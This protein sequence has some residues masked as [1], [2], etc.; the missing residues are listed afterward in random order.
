MDV[1]HFGETC[2]SVSEAV[3]CKVVS[4]CVLCLNI[5]SSQSS[6]DRHI[7]CLIQRRTVGGQG[8]L[9]TISDQHHAWICCGMLLREWLTLVHL[10]CHVVHHSEFDRTPCQVLFCETT[11]QRQMTNPT[12][13]VGILTDQHVSNFSE[14]F[15]IAHGTTPSPKAT[16]EKI[17]EIGHFILLMERDVVQTSLNCLTI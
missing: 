5:Q 2:C 1:S 12:M 4:F 10:L 16:K 7:G 9:K 8:L 3:E 15:N 14:K 17:L 13:L 11:S 6:T